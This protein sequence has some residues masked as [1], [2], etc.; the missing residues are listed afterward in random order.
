MRQARRTRPDRARE[1]S[2]GARTPCPLDRQELKPSAGGIDS[3]RSGRLGPADRAFQAAT[4]V[5]AG[6]VGVAPLWCLSDRTRE[7]GYYQGKRCRF[8]NGVEALGLEPGL[9]LDLGST[10]TLRDE[11]EREPTTR[12]TREH[13]T[14]EHRGVR[15]AVPPLASSA[16][17]LRPARPAGAGPRRGG[18][19]LPLLRRRA[20]RDRPASSP[21]SGSS[22]SCSPTSARSS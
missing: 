6:R 20:T 22:R 10:V 7:E 14:D 13:R 4:V 9:D 21:P 2:S 19:G 1:P 3:R 16:A 8:D 5:T 15:A 18:R 17:H 12:G 11:G